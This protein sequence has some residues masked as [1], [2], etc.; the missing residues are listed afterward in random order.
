M[1]NQKGFTLVELVV[2]IVILG[3]LSA[4]AV[5]KFVDMQNEAKQAAI[6]GARGSVKSAVG[7]VHAK[8]LAAG[9]PTGTVAVEGGTVTIDSYGYP[10]AD[11]AGIMTAAGLDDGDANTTD[12]FTIDTTN[13]A[14]E[15]YRT[16]D[17]TSDDD[18]NGSAK[19]GAY[20]FTYTAA[21]DASTPPV[22]SDINTKQ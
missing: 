11:A 9:E 14:V 8:W 22:V 19:S 2:V 5:P 20:Y 15:I 1:N 17:E 6:E 12:D 3:I 18:G 10:T 13:A 16:S 4:V 7:L 21:A